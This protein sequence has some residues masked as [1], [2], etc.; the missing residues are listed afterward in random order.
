METSGIRII[1]HLWIGRQEDYR[2]VLIEISKKGYIV[3]YVHFP[4]EDKGKSYK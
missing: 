4:G 2:K 1:L 3:G